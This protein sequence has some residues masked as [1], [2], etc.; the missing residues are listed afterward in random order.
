MTEKFVVL[1]D[2]DCYGIFDTR[3][4]A[5][6]YILSIAEESAYEDFLSEIMFPKN[7][8]ERGKLVK[9]D[10]WMTIDKYF[11]YWKLEDLDGVWIGHRPQ[12][13]QTVYSA[14]LASY[15]E[16]FIIMKAPYFAA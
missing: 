12:P 11:S 7:I 3:A 15:V 8:F 2:E 1:Y 5:E 13:R 6:E 10:I 9:E 16:E 4:D 14:M